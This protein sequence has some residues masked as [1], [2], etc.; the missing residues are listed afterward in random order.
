M[1]AHEGAVRYGFFGVGR[2]RRRAG[3][4]RDRSPLSPT[5]PVVLTGVAQRYVAALE[6]AGVGWPAG[7][8]RDCSL[9]FPFSP[10][11]MTGV[12]QRGEAVS[13]VAGV[14]K[15]AVQ[16]CDC[17]TLSPIFPAVLTG[18]AWWRLAV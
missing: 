6:V 12:A 17:S 14:G 7:L 9:L 1:V 13:E 15:R 10:D 2:T 4:A 11:D 16:A 8:A 3:P 5:F 18:P